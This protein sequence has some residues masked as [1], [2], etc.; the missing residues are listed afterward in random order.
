MA[1]HLKTIAFCLRR[2][3]ACASDGSHA[4]SAAFLYQMQ[5][6]ENIADLAVIYESL[7]VR[8][9]LNPN[10]LEPDSSSALL[11]M[12]LMTPLEFRNRYA[13]RRS[14]QQYCVPIQLQSLCRY[15][16]GPLD[17]EP[18]QENLLKRCFLPNINRYR[19]YVNRR[20]S[21]ME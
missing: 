15:L 5:H 13:F 8:Y 6:L 17:T 7:G 9:V 20:S 16:H 2:R 11:E 14:S 1:M 12:G 3:I 19:E 4:S 18:F 21:V 10:Y